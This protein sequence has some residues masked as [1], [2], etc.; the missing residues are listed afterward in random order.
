MANDLWL[1]GDEFLNKVYHILPEI[2]VQ[3]RANKT[4]FPYIYDYY[5]LHCYTPNPVTMINSTLARDVNCLIKALNESLK[6][7]KLIVFILDTDLIDYIMI[8]ANSE[9][10]SAIHAGIS[11]ITTQV[12]RAVMG[13]KDNIMR[14]CPG[15][16]IAFEPKIVWVN[17]INPLQN[18]GLMAYNNILRDIVMESDISHHYMDINEVMY[19]ENN[20]FDHNY[21]LNG[22]G[23]VKF[24]L[25]LDKAI[26][27]FDKKK[28]PLRPETKE[29]RPKT[30][31]KLGRRFHNHNRRNADRPRGKCNHNDDSDDD[32]EA[33]H[34]SGVKSVKIFH[35]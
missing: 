31:K 21:R 33:L 4:P 5:N 29:N 15:V 13:K 35:R 1:I 18:S 32:D 19:Q 22:T 12:N 7:P 11:W 26:E 17:A 30:M 14:R 24:W 27:M 10:K 6:L 16:I 8:T 9:R 34:T 20:C 23:R 3:A 25:E 28:L 2:R